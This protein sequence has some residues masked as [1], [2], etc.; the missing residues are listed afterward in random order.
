MSLQYTPCQHE[1]SQ[2]THVVSAPFILPFTAIDATMLP[3][4]GGK[5]ANLG[6]LVK[7]SLPVPQGFCITTAAY[8]RVS[9]DANL[10]GTLSRLAAT[11]SGE[12]E[13]LEAC[14]AAMRAALLATPIP[15]DIVRDIT[16]AYELLG[17]GE[18]IAVAVRSSANAEDLP[19][20][21][22][23]GQQD[24]YLN[25]VGVDAVLTAVKHCWASL[26]TNRAV[27]YRASNGIDHRTVRLA[28]VVQRMV[29]AH[30]AGV[31]FTA[32]PLTGRRRQAVINASPGLGEAVVSGA[33][34][35]DQFV[36]D[37]NTGE[38]IER[39]LGDKQFMLQAT[40]GGG[41]QRVELTERGPCLSDGQIADLARL[42]A[43]VETYYGAPQDI[44]WAIDATNQLWLTQARP[45]TTLFPLPDSVP[46]ANDSLR[47][48]LCFNVLQ[49]VY[50]PFTPMGFAALRLMASSIA[51]RIGFPRGMCVS[52]PRPYR[53]RAIVS[54]LI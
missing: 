42:G 26:W 41:L 18:S 11:A 36:I 38:M 43:R 17:K 48:Y 47:V 6:Q 25:V 28:V 52:D 12:S 32:N 22:F 39:C 30:V 4:V 21:S 2:D 34:N 31:L 15:A 50:R 49:G 13:V 33:V 10:E 46:S 29:E 8:L 23:A 37:V 24:T 16:A 1:T 54:L 9:G 45:I 44:E 27:S 51:R 3:S 5:A 20:A 53:K 35:P 14:A 19:F 7:A 40:P